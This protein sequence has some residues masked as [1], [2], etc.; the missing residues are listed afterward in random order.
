MELSEDSSELKTKLPYVLHIPL[1]DI[2]APHLPQRDFFLKK[3]HGYFSSIMI[4]IKKSVP[5]FMFINR[6]IGKEVVE[7]IPKGILHS[8]NEK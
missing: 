5:A 6:G 8:C 1:L 3:I 4:T 2:R 7:H